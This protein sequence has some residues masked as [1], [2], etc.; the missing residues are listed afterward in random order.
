MRLQFNKWGVRGSD[1]VG[2]SLKAEPKGEEAIV[3]LVDGQPILEFEAPS[4]VKPW[5]RSASASLGG[6]TLVF[7]ARIS[8][9]I[10]GVVLIYTDMYM[11]GKGWTS[12][13][14]LETVEEG[15]IGQ[16]ANPA[17]YI[18][19]PAFMLFVAQFIRFAPFMG[20]IALVQA[21]AR[22]GQVGQIPAVLFGIAV[23]LI[24]ATA[25]SLVGAR[26]VGRVVQTGRQV[27]LR[28]GLICV[29]V[30]VLCIATMMALYLGPLRFAISTAGH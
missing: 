5:T 6:H 22:G 9:T 16:M 27:T 17:G 3:V 25:V 29:A 18:S 10:T 12:G 13:Q 30:F 1:G 8:H 21:L 2:H 15:W 19:N 20:A 24:V 28:S 11:D 26:V 14:A 7:D 4:K 23:Y